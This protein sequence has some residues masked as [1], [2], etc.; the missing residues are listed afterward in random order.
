[1]V[2]EATV[3]RAQRITRD[4]KVITVVLGFAVTTP[5]E[6][7]QHIVRCTGTALAEASIST[8]GFVSIADGAMFIAEINA[9]NPSVEQIDKALETPHAD[10]TVRLIDVIDTDHEDAAMVAKLV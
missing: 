10:F 6:V 4:G 5:N 7:R 2:N 8:A 3:V 9:P 1:M